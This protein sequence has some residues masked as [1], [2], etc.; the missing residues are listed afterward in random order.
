MPLCARTQV[1]EWSA[2]ALANL[3]SVT[4]TPDVHES[5]LEGGGA[6][7]AVMLL[8]AC[9]LT[10]EREGGLRCARFCLGL[11]AHL[12]R[13]PDGSEE[14]VSCGFVHAAVKVLLDAPPQVPAAA[15]LASEACRAFATLAFGAAEGKAAL[16]ESG[17]RRALTAACDKYPT[18]P[19]LQQM[20]RALLLEF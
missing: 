6:G 16:R 5:I 17:A 9:D 2:A 8:K 10:S 14:C 1:R 4:G 20:A 18:E 3:A 11:W 19:E 7:A 12:G 13:E 15:A